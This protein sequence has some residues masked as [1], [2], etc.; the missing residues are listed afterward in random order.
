MCCA[1]CLL[2]Y[3]CVGVGCI[4]TVN[5]NREGQVRKSVHDGS[6]VVKADK[7]AWT[8]EPEVGEGTVCSLHWAHM[9]SRSIYVMKTA[10]AGGKDGVGPNP[11]WHREHLEVKHVSTSLSHAWQGMHEGFLL[12]S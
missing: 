1:T 6:R 4:K 2:V 8:D 12:W 3:E 10:S 11:A 9:K 7:K 5:S